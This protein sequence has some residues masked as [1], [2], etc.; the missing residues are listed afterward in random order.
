MQDIIRIH[1]IRTGASLG[2]SLPFEH[3]FGLLHPFRLV[4]ERMVCNETAVC[5]FT[6]VTVTAVNRDEGGQLVA[7]LN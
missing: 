6:D 1:D 4:T 3:L 5:G 7:E 2:C